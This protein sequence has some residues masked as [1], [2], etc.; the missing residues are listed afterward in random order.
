[1]SCSSEEA[2]ALNVQD[3]HE[4]RGEQN[5]DVAMR[6]PRAAVRFSPSKKKRIYIDHNDITGNDIYC[7]KKFRGSKDPGNVN[8]RDTISTNKADYEFFGNN[9]GKKTKLST[10]LLEDV[11]TG[12]FIRWC[13]EGQHYYLL[14]KQEARTKIS[15]ALCD[16]K[17]TPREITTNSPSHNL[18]N[19]P[20]LE[21]QKHFQEEPNEP[22]GK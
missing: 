22:Y 16:K 7:G 4:P 17:R 2:P 15:Q 19:L 11:F 18:M 8:F 21:I 6:A 12:A 9:H 10:R 13:D 20:I 14:T 3:E 1:M 5:N